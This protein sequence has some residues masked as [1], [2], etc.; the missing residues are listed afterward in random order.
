MSTASMLRRAL[1]VPAIRDAADTRP[2]QHA[3][4]TI[5]ASRVVTPTARFIAHQ[6]LRKP[7]TYSL[8]ATGDRVTVRHRSR[9]IAILNEIFAAGSYQPPPGVRIP[10]GARVLD[11]GGNIGLF[12][13]YALAKLHAV[14]VRSYEPDPENVELLRATAAHH[15]AWQVVEAAVAAAPGMMRFASGFRSESRAADETETSIDVSVLDVF[16]EPHAD[17]I[18]IDIEGGE[19]PILNDPRMSSLTDMIVLEWHARGCP[20]GDGH[21]TAHRLLARARYINRVDTEHKHAGNGVLW[22]WK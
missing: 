5:R 18:K 4:Q 21:A 8:R 11:L 22:A 6:A 20:G 17:L 13:L 16:D 1:A 14:S 10:E 19:W 12:G 7:G 15:P 2:A 9:D 3:I